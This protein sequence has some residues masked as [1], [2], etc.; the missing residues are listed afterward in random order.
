[1]EQETY[2]L[3]K[4]SLMISDLNALAER[5]RQSSEPNKA[6][7]MELVKTRTS[8]EKI[9]KFLREDFTRKGKEVIAKEKELIAIIEP[10]EK[11]LK[12]LEEAV[13][14]EEMLKVRR[15]QIPERQARLLSIGVL[16]TE[17]YLLGLDSVQFEQFFND[18]QAE[19][20]NRKQEELKKR[21]ADLLEAENKLKEEER[22]K[23]REEL[24]RKQERDR[25][26]SE[27]VAEEEKK[28]IEKERLEKEQKFT[29]WRASLGYT[30][31]N[32]GEFLQVN[33][34]GEIVLWK[35]LGTFKL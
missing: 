6:L 19:I 2:T 29:E 4:Y 33:K 32:S 21:E 24:A 16:A 10:E 28:R 13:E 3:E 8:L 23:E 11:R 31:E 25:I 35:K 1:M 22:A 15:L 12:M 17:E 27:R 18:N 9:G 7:R 30:K 20:N 26:E 34:D 14:R 5:A